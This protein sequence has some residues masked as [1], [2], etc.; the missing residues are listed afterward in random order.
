M[1]TE[2]DSFG[3]RPGLVQAITERGYTTPTPIQAGMI[4]LMLSGADVIG[5]AQ[6]G[7]GKTAAFALP[8]LQN[9]EPG[10]KLPQALVLAPTRELAMQVADAFYEYGKHLGA[11]VLAVYGGAPYG[12]QISRLN[13]GVDVVVATPGRLL[14]LLKRNAINLRLVKTVVLD[15]AD[16]ML[17][18]GFIDDVESI[19]AQTP[20]TRQTALFSATLP[21]PIRRLADKY[22]RDPQSVTI[23]QEQV[24]AEMIEQRCYLVNQRDKLAAL[25]RLF[26]VEDITSALIFVRTRVGTGEL[27]NELT[28][29][30]FPAEML[31]GDLSQDA[32]ERTMSRFRNNQIK[33]LVATDVAARGLDVDDI[34]HVFNYDLPDETE[35]YVH[36]IG[37]TGRAGK[38]GL[39]ITLVSPREKSKLAGI[40]RFTHQKFTY[41]PLPTETD[42]QQKRENELLERMNVWLNRGRYR[43]ELE[44]VTALAEAG[45][46]PLE[47]A[48]AALKMARADE[49]QRPI[50]PLSEVKKSERKPR[51]FD[52][53][54]GHKSRRNGRRSERSD[55][56]AKVSHEQGMVR[57]SM[58]LGRTDGIRPADVVGTIAYHADIPGNTIG[59]IFIEDKH[60]FV[61]VPESLVGKV[62]SKKVD[63]KFRRQPVTVEKA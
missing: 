49:K 41:L 32:R 18:M 31:N 25:T 20:E 58:N 39:A 1:T 7:T 38:T 12:R 22:M 13:K 29:R 55:H 5:Q 24:T 53:D 56:R 43:R 50:D 42:I 52:R 47:L 57:V 23:Q 17:K 34:S 46:D 62:L 9:L 26:E 60:T 15:E 4:P 14:D 3:L 63:Y 48:A 54:N 45:H 27:A 8:I 2:F 30:G 37:R 10:Q 19:L 35:V 21:S 28:L 6:T 11:R 51:K 33:V 44:L 59:K 16:E 36:R 40:E 61:D